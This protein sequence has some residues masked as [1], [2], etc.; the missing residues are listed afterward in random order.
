MV[1]LDKV[2]VYVLFKDVVRE[3]C[4]EWL[5]NVRSN[6]SNELWW[7]RVRVGYGLFRIDRDG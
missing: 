4:G 2:G 7:E 5:Y 6:D 3:E 1:F